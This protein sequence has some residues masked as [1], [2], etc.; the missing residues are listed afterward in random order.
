MELL[1]TFEYEDIKVETFYNGT[2]K[3]PNKTY[4]NSELVY[5]DETYRPSPL[6]DIDSDEVMIGLLGF[7]TL[8]KDD[9]ED[10]F[11]EDRGN[12]KLTNWAE[13][14]NAENIKLMINDFEM[15]D[16]DEWLDDNELDYEDARI[17]TNYIN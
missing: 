3:V 11:F 17:I 16:D 7:L 14:Q 13:T 4:I 8:T 12:S 15:C 1:Q 9:V 6:Y 2:D 10:E 5:E